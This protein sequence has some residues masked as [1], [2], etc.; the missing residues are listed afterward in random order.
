MSDLDDI[1]SEPVTVKAGGREVQV[2]PMVPVQIA[3]FARAIKPMSGAVPDSVAG[4]RKLDKA[5]LLDLFAD[6]GEQIIAAVAAATDEDEAFIGTQCQ[7]DELLEL[8]ITVFQVNADFFARRLAPVIL[9]FV[10]SAAARSNGAGRTPSSSSS[11]TA[12][13]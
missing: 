13:N 2:R 10:D 9:R 1:I 11:A 7:V 4:A 8:A 3:R 12:T 6:H 5:A